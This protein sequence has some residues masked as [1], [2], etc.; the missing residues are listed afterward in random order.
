M[1]GDY[2]LP[3]RFGVCDNAL[4]A[5]DFEVLLVRPSRRVWEAALAAFLP[6]CLAGAFRCDIALPAADFEALPV[7]VLVSVFEALLA[8]GPLVTFR[9]LA[10]VCSSC[11][12]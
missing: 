3:F 11:S 1:N 7:D 10:I 6:V 5:A 2:Y 8:A 12:N 9:F 4:P